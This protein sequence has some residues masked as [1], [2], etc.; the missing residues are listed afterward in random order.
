MWCIP[1]CMT[2]ELRSEEV[3]KEYVYAL[4]TSNDQGLRV[5]YT[6][7]T[8]HNHDSYNITH[9]LIGADKS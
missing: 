6:Q 2:W 4:E 7:N 8:P 3:C 5:I 9:M 1:C